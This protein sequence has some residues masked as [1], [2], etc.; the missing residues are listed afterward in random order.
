MINVREKVLEY[1]ITDD[2]YTS[3]DS[4]RILS[5]YN[6]ATDEQRLVVDSIFTSLCGFPLSDITEESKW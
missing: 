1:I 5:V 3:T 6:K 2:S 4:Q